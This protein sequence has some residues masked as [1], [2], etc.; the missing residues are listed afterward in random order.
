M[1]HPLT[2]KVMRIS[3]PSLQLQSPTYVDPV[4]SVPTPSDASL[5]LKALE[6]AT[7]TTIPTFPITNHAILPP[8]FGVIY[9]GQTFSSLVCVNNDGEEAVRGVKIRAEIQ[10]HSG[11]VVELD[12]ETAT[13][14]DKREGDQGQG[15]VEV[16][17]GKSIRRVISHDIREVGPHVLTITVSYATPSLP[18]DADTGPNS[19]PEQTTHSFRKIFKFSGRQSLSVKTKVNDFQ[20]SLGAK[21]GENVILEVQ[22]QSLEEGMVMESLRFLP[23]REWEVEDLNT[24]TAPSSSDTNSGGTRKEEKGIFES[25]AVLNPGSVWQYMFLLSKRP[26]EGGPGSRRVSAEAE[27]I[28]AGRG[29]QLGRLEINWRTSMGEVGKLVTSALVRRVAPR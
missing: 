15:E 11:V 5:A 2:L 22:I 24:F 3:R 8:S 18:S 4:S 27:A 9:V 20:P 7:T 23:A 17:G 19:N 13:E 6:E 14:N 28:M 10:T 12:P 1:D 26:L 16:E 29:E 25:L 21:V